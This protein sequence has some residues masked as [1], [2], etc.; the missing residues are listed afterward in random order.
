MKFR[1][2][3][4]L[5]GCLLGAFLGSGTVIVGGFGRIFGVLVFTVLGGLIGFLAVPDSKRVIEFFQSRKRP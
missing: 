3:G 5:A 2:F 1:I 4:S